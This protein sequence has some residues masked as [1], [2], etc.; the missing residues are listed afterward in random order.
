MVKCENS[1]STC[2]LT[3]IDF[4]RVLPQTGKLVTE[5]R[6][7]QKIFIK[8]QIIVR[9]HPKICSEKK[10]DFSVFQ[11]ES[12]CGS[13]GDGDQMIWDGQLGPSVVKCVF[14]VWAFSSYL[15][16]ETWH[17]FGLT[18]TLTEYM[19]TKAFNSLKT[20]ALEEGITNDLNMISEEL[21]NYKHHGWEGK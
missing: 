21:I 14:V 7:C 8:S 9:I 20:L 6:I 10:L 4:V 17:Y 3:C 16:F 18:W 5:V 2:A 12:K 13:T 11:L 19:R 15:H 1:A